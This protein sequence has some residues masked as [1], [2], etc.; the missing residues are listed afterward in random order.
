MYCLSYLHQASRAVAG[1]EKS[2]DVSRSVAV[3]TDEASVQL[4]AE[5]ARHI[6]AVCCAKS[7]EQAVDGKRAAVGKADAAELAVAFYCLQHRGV[8]LKACSLGCVAALPVGQDGDAACQLFKIS[9]LMQ[10]VGTVA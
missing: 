10:S 6:G 8:Y 5:L 4:C 2:G 3:D 9:C 1:S 7:D